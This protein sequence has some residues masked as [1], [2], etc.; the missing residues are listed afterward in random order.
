MIFVQQVVGGLAIGLVYGLVALGFVLLLR[1]LDLINFAQGEMMMAG[2]FLALGAWQGLGLPFPL[3]FLA[4]LLATAGLGLLMDRLVAHPLRH[5]PLIHLVIATVAVSLL[6]KNVGLLLG[7]P[8]PLPFPSLFG[9]TPVAVGPI[10]LVPQT[11]LILGA[12]LGLVGLLQIFLLRTRRGLALRAIMADPEMAA[13]LGVPPGQ[14]RAL[15]FSLSA[16]LGATGGIL[17][18]PLVFV[19]FDMG[20][21]GLKAF[22]AAALGGLYSIPGAIGGGLALGVLENLLAGTIS[23]GYRD[24]LVYAVLIAVLVGRAVR[25]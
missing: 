22:T 2:A 4:A 11:F 1:S 6:L 23:S 24:V 18:A 17:I 15:A 13:L 9:E 5:A 12:A 21:L 20:S 16:A 3:A 14:A 10:R 19:S 25:R 7:G 8:E